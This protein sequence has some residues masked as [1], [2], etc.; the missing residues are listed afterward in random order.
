MM[1]TPVGL[2]LFGSV[3]IMTACGDPMMT[4]PPEELSIRMIKAVP[5]FRADIDEIIQRRGCSSSSCHSRAP[6]EA[7]AGLWLNTNPGGNYSMLVN[8]DAWSEPAYKRVLPGDADNSYLM[9]KLE[10]RQLVGLQMPRNAT[11]LDSIDITNIRNWIN[12]GAPNN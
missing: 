11:P 4:P 1:R 8:A 9:I 2:V 7:Q 6:R 3:M 5:T 12:N 10:G